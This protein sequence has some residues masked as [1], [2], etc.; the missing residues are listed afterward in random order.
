MRKSI[1]LLS[2]LLCLGSAAAF[3][4]SSKKLDV[5]S[6]DFKDGD[7]IPSEHTCDGANKLPE[8]S[9]STV[10]ADA[11]SVA[12]LVDDPDA[13]NGGYTHLLVT[14]ISPSLTSLAEG[15]SMPSG[16]TVVSN[17]RGLKAYTG[18]C[19]TN[20][21][22]HHYHFR[23]Y[24]LDTTTPDVASRSSFKAAIKGHVLAEGE[25]VGTYKAR[26]MGSNR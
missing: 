12:I 9:W 13:P 2:T 11:K 21:S 5:T 20:S 6:A 18:P 23:V 17:D 22:T 3:A 24:A 8:L 19:P 7:A 16:A 1:S 25:V 4:D 14:G 10:P 26:S 15:A